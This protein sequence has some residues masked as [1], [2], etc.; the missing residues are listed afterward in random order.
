MDMSAHDFKL[1]LFFVISLIILHWTFVMVI[2]IACL[3]IA[4]MKGP[5]YVADPTNYLILQMQTAIEIRC[6]NC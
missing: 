6:F 3:I 1:L 5:A 4:L 2:G